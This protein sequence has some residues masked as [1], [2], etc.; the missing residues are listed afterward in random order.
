MLAVMEQKEKE[1]FLSDIGCLF[2]A[3]A[4]RFVGVVKE[5][6]DDKIKLVTEQYLGLREDFDGM[7]RILDSHT[8]MIGELA[9]DMV[10]VRSDLKAIKAGLDTKADERD[11]VVL[12]RRINTLETKRV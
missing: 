7:K 8:E 2:E 5:Y 3:H 9:V 4:E 11:V 6:F 12:D 1:D 10:V